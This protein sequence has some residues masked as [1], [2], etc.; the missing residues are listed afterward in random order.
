LREVA[1]PQLGNQRQRLV[2]EE[3]S[4]NVAQPVGRGRPAGYDELDRIPVVA[5][6]GSRAFQA[7][8]LEPSATELYENRICTSLPSSLRIA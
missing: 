2:R 5:I 7:W 4:E 3:L 8:I 1:E 6:V